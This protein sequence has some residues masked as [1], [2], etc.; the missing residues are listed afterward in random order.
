MEKSPE[1]WDFLLEGLTLKWPII[2]LFIFIF[3]NLY[4]CNSW[5]WRRQNR[6]LRPTSKAHSI[7]TESTDLCLNAN[8]GKLGTS[9]SHTFCFR[10]IAD[11]FLQE[12]AT[13]L[14]LCPTLLGWGWTAELHSAFYFSYYLYFFI[15]AVYQTVTIGYGTVI[16]AILAKFYDPF[17]STLHVFTILILTA[18]LWAWYYYYTCQCK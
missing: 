14:F 4:Y 17:L 13:S 10:V 5:L 11:P 15:S 7:L 18:T 2:P 16:A 3:I 9:W 1:K 6:L 8:C 12:T